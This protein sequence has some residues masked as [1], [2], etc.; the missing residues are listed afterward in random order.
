M[1][2]EQFKKW[3]ESKGYEFDDDDFW[4]E[5]QLIDHSF[6]DVINLIKEFV[7]ENNVKDIIRFGMFLTGHDKDTIEQIH[8][9]WKR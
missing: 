6:K 5:E 8:N 9:D 3:F 2:T 1:N 7:S 4:I